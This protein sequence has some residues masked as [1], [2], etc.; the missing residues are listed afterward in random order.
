MP[1]GRGMAM[2]AS[3]PAM[4]ALARALGHYEA[5]RL[6]DAGRACRVALAVHPADADLLFL[7]A[8]VAG[9]LGR[10][11]EAATLLRRVVRLRPDHGEAYRNLIGVLCRAGQPQEAVP[12][13]VAWIAHGPVDHPA[14][15]IALADMLMPASEADAV[16]LV[17][18]ALAR[19]PD[20]VDLHLARARQHLATGAL[21]RAIDG[22][23]AAVDRLPSAMPLR[24]ALVA[25]CRVSARLRLADDPADWLPRVAQAWAAIAAAPAM[26]EALYHALEPLCGFALLG[27][28]RDIALGITGA[29]NAID[30]ADVPAGET[31]IFAVELLDFDRWC[32][33]SGFDRHVIDAAAQPLPVDLASFYPACLQTHIA[34]LAESGPMSV[35]VGARVEILQGFYVKDNYE[36]H[37]LADR[38]RMLRERTDMAV[39][40]PRVPL[41]GVTP[42]L[43]GGMI[44]IP[45]PLYPVIEVE[46]SALFLP[47][48]PNY[49]HFLVDILPRLLV[50][51][52][53]AALRDL[54]IHLFDLR[55]FQREML[56][57]AGIPGERIVDFAD[58][59]PGDTALYRHRQA[60]L[61]S[62]VPY[63]VAVRWLRERFLPG[64]DLRAEAGRRVYLTRRG[65]APRHRIA[66][67]GAVAAL[68]ETHGFRILQ[69]ERMSVRETVDLI[70]RAEIVV[71][72]IGAGT[73]NQIFLPPEGCWLHLNNPDFYH[74]TSRWNAQMGVQIPLVGRSMNLTGRFVADDLPG[75]L[76]ERLDVPVDIDLDRLDAIVSRLVSDR[77]ASR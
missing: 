45:R 33:A 74:E 54:P 30:F 7:L 53:V 76:L 21:D 4:A 59:V 77:A 50:C 42:G 8:V 17:E 19:N 69:P 60:V 38:R 12:V 48:T 52:H 55:P 73:A 22:L 61:P 2:S 34:S 20:V 13:A 68:L 67:D 14:P 41:I 11:D 57:L 51:D 35:A 72:P 31:D 18:A 65:S 71:A 40:G 39:L 70:S 64:G 26:T 24:E 66:N 6:A 15:V 27:G 1:M 56:E 37:I 75:D 49:W 63:P 62:A 29:R 28:A 43:T 23:A 16:A 3:N 44:R 5:G 9:D 32:A 10:P 36:H 25:L 46:G 58:R 47:S